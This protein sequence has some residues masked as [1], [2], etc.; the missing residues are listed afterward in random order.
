MTVTTLILSLLCIFECICV[1]AIFLHIRLWVVVLLYIIAVLG[2]FF[3]LWR[4]KQLPEM[5]KEQSYC[6]T[7]EKDNGWLKWKCACILLIGFQLLLVVFYTHID[8]DD[9]WYLGTASAAYET[10][11]MFVYSP[12]TGEPIP[13]SDGGDYV[14]S[15]LPMLWAVL[16]KVFFVHPTIIAH[17]IVPIFVLLG[18]YCVYYM[19][20]KRLFHT[21]KS[22][23]LFVFFLC[24]LN[25]FGYHSTRTTGVFLLFRSWQGKAIF[26]TVLV[27]LLFYYFL[28]ICKA[29]K[30]YKEDLKGMYLT[31]GAGC[32][33]SFSAVSLMPLL[34]GAMALTVAVMKKELRLPVVMCGAMIPNVILIL[35]YVLAL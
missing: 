12:Y 17:T 11:E 18:A 30:E 3:V 28:G 34:L 33:V 6:K 16:G 25:I 13:L 26:C 27:P 8:D 14:L 4:K 31:M 2:Y 23:W 1:P 32:L 29:Q 7:I 20:G 5:R 19:L 22:A 21:T 24:L 10:G 9:A 15:P 35:I